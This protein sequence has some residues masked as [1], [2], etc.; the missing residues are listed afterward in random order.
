MQKG[1]FQLQQSHLSMDAPLADGFIRCENPVVLDVKQII[2]GNSKEAAAP[3][4]DI[5]CTECAIHDFWNNSDLDL[6]ISKQII[7]EMKTSFGGK[8]SVRRLPALLQKHCGQALS[9]VFQFRL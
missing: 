8:I 4:F 2:T 6:T 5:F 1:R 9:L 7:G 3:M